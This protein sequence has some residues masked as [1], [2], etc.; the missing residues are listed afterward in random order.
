[1]YLARGLHRGKSHLDEGE[2]LNVEKIPFEEVF[3][4]V[5]RNEIIDAKTVI[6]FS[7]AKLWLEG[8]K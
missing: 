5:M 3:N 4:M 1:M 7:K 2:F 6:A 8:H